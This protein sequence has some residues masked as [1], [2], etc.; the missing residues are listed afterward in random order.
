MCPNL[1]TNGGLNPHFGNVFANVLMRLVSEFLLLPRKSVADSET[2]QV[3]GLVYG[4]LQ[5]EERPR[6]YILRRGGNQRGSS[7]S[8]PGKVH[9]E[10]H[11]VA[12]DRGRRAVSKAIRQEVGR[13]RRIA[14]IGAEGSQAPSYYR[15]L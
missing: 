9:V 7:V 5:R 10:L 6:L 1:C 14:G 2:T 3:A 13:V 4:F 8:G 15:E 12:V 11:G